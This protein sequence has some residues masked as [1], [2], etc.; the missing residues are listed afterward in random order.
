MAAQES[1]TTER[2]PTG[3]GGLP[4]RKRRQK[5]SFLA[6]H[7]FLLIV[8][9]TMVAPFLWMVSTA[10]KP[11]GQVQ[12][13]NWVPTRD[14]MLVDGV[15]GEVVRCFTKRTGSW[16][17]HGRDGRLWLERLQIRKDDGELTMLNLDAE[18]AIMVLRSS[19]A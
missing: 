13:P 17:A 19:E 9:V 14:Y 10:L 6:S 7:V 8:A 1:P 2:A 5:L 12:R 3:R 18:S 15:E 16:H 4:S 11:R